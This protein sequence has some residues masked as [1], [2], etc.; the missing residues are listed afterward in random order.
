MAQTKPKPASVAKKWSPKALAAAK[1]F[2]GIKLAKLLPHQ[3]SARSA[4]IRRAVR[5]FYLG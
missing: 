1:A 3:K 4:A 2:K 5:A